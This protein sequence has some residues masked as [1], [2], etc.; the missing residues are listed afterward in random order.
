MENKARKYKIGIIEEQED[1]INTFKRKLKEDFDVHI[2]PLTFDLTKEALNSQIESQEL[3]CLIA[4]YDLKE[5]DIVQFNGDEVIELYRKKYPHFPVFIITSKD[6]D[7]VLPQISDNEIV[8]IKDELT[9]KTSILI[10]RIKNKIDNYYSEIKN[11]EDIIQQLV[12]L[13]NSQDLTI[14]QEEELANKYKF[15]GEIYPEEK[16][17]PDNWIQP[18][19][20]TRLDKFLNTSKAILEELKKLNQ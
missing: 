8:R 14:Q 4:D 3:D 9:D 15:L 10:Q 2:F 17:L 19:N 1:W 12:E 18:E 20:I 13:K 7:D 16:L 5:A 11:A 6:E